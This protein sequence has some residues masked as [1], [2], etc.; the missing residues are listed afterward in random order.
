MRRSD[1]DTRRG[2]DGQ[3]YTDGGRRASSESQR[4]HRGGEPTFNHIEASP[5]PVTSAGRSHRAHP[6]S[7]LSTTANGDDPS[8]PASPPLSPTLE[9]T[10]RQGSLSVAGESGSRKG[11][12]TAPDKA[13]NRRSGFYGL[14]APRTS[15]DEGVAGEGEEA[16]VVGRK[17]PAPPLA[18]VEDA[19]GEEE[20]EEDGEERED[21]EEL[22]D[23]PLPS[24]ASR[25]FLP[26]LHNSVSFYDPD[27]LLF[28]D[29]VGSAPSSPKL[30]ATKGAPR[31]SSELSQVPPEQVENLSPDVGVGTEEEDGGEGGPRERGGEP[32][33]EVARRVRESIQSSRMSEGGAAGGMGSTLDV[34]LVEMLLGE[35]DGTKKEMKELQ[36]K[37]N[38][39]RVSPSVCWFAT[40][41]LANAVLTLSP[42]HTSQRA[43]RSAFE[44]FSMARE[45]YDKEVAA[46]RETE[47]RM[48]QLRTKFI[49]QAQRLATVDK[50]QKHAEA[51]K[52]QSKELRSSVVGM[53]K[54]LSI[55]RA[56][57]ELSTAQAAELSAMESASAEL[58]VFD[59]DGDVRQ[60]S[61]ADPPIFTADVATATAPRRR[62]RISCKHSL[63]VSRPSRTP[64]ATRSRI[65]SLSGTS[66]RARWLRCRRS[67]TNA[68]RRRRRST[69]ATPLWPTRTRMRRD[70][71]SSC[72]SR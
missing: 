55:L 47:S 68:R 71:S 10:S 52:R 22:D 60:G 36:G 26:E 43:S 40:R 42:L 44:G 31:Y 38:A 9:S 27:T 28:L 59:L 33:S 3:L 51:L 56:E 15:V 62:A 30:H 18:I 67:G 32:K 69:C 50:E 49:E 64:T 41:S 58:Y 13:A 20:E 23:K 16:A 1:S 12:L 37:Y 72:A 61:L 46:R 65:S 21:E 35:L 66:W 34:E 7:S 54:H 24:S 19:G 5:P 11:S 63:H 53:E 25:S 45:E 4:S 70:N 8:T 29:H 14:M 17:S 39:F 57:V 2:S 48:D 6:P